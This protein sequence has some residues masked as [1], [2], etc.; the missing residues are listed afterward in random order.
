MNAVIGAGIDAHAWKFRLDHVDDT[1]GD[2]LLVGADRHQIGAFDTGCDQ[3]IL[4]GAIAEKDAEPETGG[5]THTVGRTVDD[6]HVAAASKKDL[7]GDLAEA[8][9]ADHQH[10]RTRPVEILFQLVLFRILRGQPPRNH[11]QNRRQRHGERDDG[12]EDR[13]RGLRKQADAAAVVKSTKPNSPPCARSSAM[14]LDA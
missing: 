5:L 8:G 11:C 6:S 12:D 3:H 1:V 9:K 14:R 13:G 10:I 4:A 7:R 2:L